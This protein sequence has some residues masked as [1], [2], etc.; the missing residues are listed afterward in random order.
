M[1]SCVRA[2]E[3]P[4]KLSYSI[5][6]CQWTCLVL[7]KKLTRKKKEEKTPVRFQD[8]LCAFIYCHDGFPTVVITPVLATFFLIR[9]VVLF[10]FE[11]KELIQLWT[12]LYSSSLNIILIVGC[13]ISSAWPISRPLACW[14]KPEFFGRKAAAIRV[15]FC[16]NICFFGCCFYFY[17]VVFFSSGFCRRG[18]VGSIFPSTEFDFDGFHFDVRT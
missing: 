8:R 1:S 2:D 16:R 12:I 18:R 11:I 6:L 9:G 15:V 17:F 3:L 7:L 14:L 10:L 13:C 4:K 5:L